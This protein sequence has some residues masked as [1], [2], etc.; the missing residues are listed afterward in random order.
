MR[1]HAFFGRLD[2]DQTS[3]ESNP[4]DGYFWGLIMFLILTDVSWGPEKMRAHALFGGLD[5]DQS[6]TENIPADRSGV[7]NPFRSDQENIFLA[8]KQT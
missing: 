4:A 1:V 5:H 8:Q 3:T 2:H 7:V 6:S